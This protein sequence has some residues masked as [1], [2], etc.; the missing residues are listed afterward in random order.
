VVEVEDAVGWLCSVDAAQ[1]FYIFVFLGS[2]E[3]GA[4]VLRGTSIR[5]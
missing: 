3:E 1:G 2:L 5:S 4:G